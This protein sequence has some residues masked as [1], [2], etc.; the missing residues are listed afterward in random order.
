MLEVIAFMMLFN[1]GF[2][3]WFAS[4]PEDKNRAVLY[5]ISVILL[6]IWNEIKKEKK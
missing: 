3:M 1:S 6:G 5:F 2:T 4:C